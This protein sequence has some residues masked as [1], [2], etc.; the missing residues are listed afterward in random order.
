MNNGRYKFT[1]S[2]RSAGGRA[3]KS[4][5]PPPVCPKCG[6]KMNGRN[7]HSYIGHL[8]LHGLADSYFGGDIAAAQKRLRENGMA[9]QDPT[10]WNNAMP[11][12]KPIG[13]KS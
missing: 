12:Y 2:D 4:K 9:K 7:W 11:K 13:E 1:K 8:G 6:L 3:V 5:R 10:P